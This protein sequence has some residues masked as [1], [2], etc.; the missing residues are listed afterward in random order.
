MFDYGPVC[1][2]YKAGTNQTWEYSNKNKT[3]CQKIVLKKTPISLG[4]T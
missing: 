1:T 4:R 3:F 2:D